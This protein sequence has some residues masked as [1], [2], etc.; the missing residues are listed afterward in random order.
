MPAMLTPGRVELCRTYRLRNRDTSLHHSAW[1]RCTYRKYIHRPGGVCRIGLSACC[2]PVCRRMGTLVPALPF[3][4]TITASAHCLLL[5]P[6][7]ALHSNTG[8]G[9]RRPVGPAYAVRCHR[10]PAHLATHVLK[11][12]ARLGTCRE[13]RHASRRPAHLHVPQAKRPKIHA[14][15]RVHGTS[16]RARM[17]A[18]G[19]NGAATMADDQAPAASKCW[20][21]AAHRA[22]DSLRVPL[23]ILY[24]CTFACRRRSAGGYLLSSLGSSRHVACEA[25]SFAGASWLVF[26]NETLWPAA[27]MLIV[28]SY[29]GWRCDLGA[30]AVT[31]A[32]LMG[33]IILLAG[34][35]YSD[36]RTAS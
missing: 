18:R 5:S 17:D 20:L 13:A 26:R 1:S 31:R 14:Y 3:A 15:I 4:A 29:L 35:D 34:L 23:N 9:R 24:F 12:A 32:G 27:G 33:R 36:Y 7:L 10:V 8:G 25:S 11:R 2:T 6:N 22:R 30:S 21:I 19:L 28:L 16:E